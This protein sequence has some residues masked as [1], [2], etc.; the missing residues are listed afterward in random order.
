MA[1]AELA[2]ISQPKNG[3]DYSCIRKN[4][5]PGKKHTKSCKFDAVFV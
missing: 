5:Q 4:K 1:C 3:A 2:L